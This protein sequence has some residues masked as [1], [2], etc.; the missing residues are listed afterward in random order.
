MAKKSPRLVSLCVAV[1]C[2]ALFMVGPAAGESLSFTDASAGVATIG[3]ARGVAVADYDGDGWDDV[4]VSVV[5]GVSSLFRNRQDG[6]F[7]DVGARAG[8]AV[9]G[10]SAV[11][12]WGDVDGDGRPDLFVGQRWGSVNRL[13]LQNEDGTFRDEGSVSGIDRRARVATAAFGDFDND[14]KLDLFLATLASPDLLYRG[15]PGESDAFFVD[16]T[17]EAGVAGLSS[18]TPM[19]ATWV[20]FDRDGDLDLFAVH[21]GYSVESRLY[22]NDGRLPLVDVAPEA[23]IASVG[24]GYSMGVAWGDVDGDGWPDAYVTRIDTG[25]LYRNNGNGTFRDVA[26]ESGAARNGWG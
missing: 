18:S 19:Q 15:A 12:L 4:Y 9:Q 11:A 17:E 7:E 21:D 13:F 8:V 16:I 3:V 14:G 26:I 6:T 25:G 5:D 22:R 23:N 2:P 20:D 10:K 1:L 24:V